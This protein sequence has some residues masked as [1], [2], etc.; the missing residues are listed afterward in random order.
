MTERVDPRRGGSEPAVEDRRPHVVVGVDGSAG[1]RAALV[2]A[3]TTAA[4]RRAALDVV[5][6]VPVGSYWTDP[7]VWDPTVVDALREET[8]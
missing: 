8:G 6:A 4:A 7:Y 5:S 1:S 2:H 3:W